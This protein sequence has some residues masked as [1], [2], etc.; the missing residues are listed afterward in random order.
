MTAVSAE[1]SLD[2]ATNLIRY[3]EPD[4]DVDNGVR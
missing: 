4:K 2:G 1:R 3:R